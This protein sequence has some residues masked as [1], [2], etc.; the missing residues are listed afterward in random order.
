MAPRQDD[1]DRGRVAQS[2]RKKPGDCKKLRELLD[3]IKLKEAAEQ[4]KPTKPA[5]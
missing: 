4:F 5:D 2:L 3:Q 1:F